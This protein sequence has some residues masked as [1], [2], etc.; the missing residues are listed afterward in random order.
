[1]DGPFRIIIKITVPASNIYN[2][3]KIVVAAK[4]DRVMLNYCKSV[5]NTLVV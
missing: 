4:Y 3:I 1:M 2:Q 5:H